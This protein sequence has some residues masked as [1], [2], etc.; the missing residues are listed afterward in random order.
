MFSIFVENQEKQLIIWKIAHI[1]LIL[2]IK[3]DQFTEYLTH[4]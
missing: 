2:E 3:S 1:R 4:S